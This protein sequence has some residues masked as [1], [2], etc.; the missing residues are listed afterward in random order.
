MQERLWRWKTTGGAYLLAT[1]IGFGIAGN[2]LANDPPANTEELQRLL[3]EP[4]FVEKV[5]R[6]NGLSTARFYGQGT[7]RMH[8]MARAYLVEE[9]HQLASGRD[10][11]TSNRSPSEIVTKTSKY[12]AEAIDNLLADPAF[13]E[14]V[15]QR[16]GTNSVRFYGQGR[17]RIHQMTRAYLEEQE[18]LQ[19]ET[20]VSA[21]S[22][23]K[24]RP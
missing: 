12:S 19:A 1:V 5:A 11:P 18:Q 16:N 9:A 15:A 14:K 6:H 21:P 17:G 22:P 20:S 23:A 24:G 3:S 10:G 8:Q 7:G 2:A 13:V 4:N